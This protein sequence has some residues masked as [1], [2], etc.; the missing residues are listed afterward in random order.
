MLYYFINGHV[1]LNPDSFQFSI[2]K[3]FSTW[4]NLTQ[5]VEARTSHEEENMLNK[6]VSHSR[7]LVDDY[8]YGAVGGRGI[9][10]GNKNTWR[11][12][13]CAVLYATNLTQPDLG[14]NSGLRDRTPETNCLNN[15]MTLRMCLNL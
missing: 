11:N 10:R 7:P 2:L 5:T 4:W 14:S 12:P 9:G 3:H 15:G 6:S 13:A 8:E 1:T